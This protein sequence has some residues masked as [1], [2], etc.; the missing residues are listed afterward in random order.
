MNDINS[1]IAKN[2]L[3]VKFTELAE[4]IN[5]KF[6]PNFKFK[7]KNV[8]DRLR[9]LRESGEKLPMKSAVMKQAHKP[10]PPL[11]NPPDVK[12]NYQLKKVSSFEET[13]NEANISYDTETKPSSVED[14][15]TKFKV[16]TTVWKV[17]RYSVNQ[18]DAFTS[19]PDGTT[20]KMP[21]FQCKVSLAKVKPDIENLPPISSI[22]VKCNVVIPKFPKAKKGE[23]KRA[24]I[25]PDSQNGYLRNFYS[26]YLEPF[27]DRD[28]WDLSVQ[29][30]DKMKP[31]RIIFL[32]DML[33]LPDWS[34]KFLR[35]PEMQYTTQP[36]L[37]ELNWWFQR[38][39]K[40]SPAAQ[41]D[42]LEG[43]HEARLSK[44]VIKYSAQMYGLQRVDQIQQQP[45]YSIANLLA[46][47]KLGITFHENYP[48]GEVWINENLIVTHGKVVR[49]GSGMTVT[50]VVKT[51]RASEIFG[52]I[53][54]IETATQTVHSHKG[55]TSYKIVSPGCICRIDGVVPG[56]SNK[57]NWQQGLAE[58]VYEEGNGMFEINIITITKGECI[59]NGEK[60]KSNFNI[61]DLIKDTNNPAFA[62]K[63]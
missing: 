44:H 63:K 2:Y 24:L 15:L 45:A 32:G 58:V 14:I 40:T 52:H 1:Y 26:G 62:I 35:T 20:K 55:E 12:G 9:R 59:Y 16:D 3:S 27:H 23:L 56:Y 37:Q 22:E 33:D 8:R 36:A 10:V 39:R 25:I 61:K 18:W 5:Y 41:M 30:A 34:D 21:M 60:Y 28:A 57:N 49:Q 29:I 46:L 48:N 6:K 19:D 51:A 13:Q 38:L 42:Y 43:N 50:N 47:D 17:E 7:E 4:R 11:I 31:D 54:R 53:H